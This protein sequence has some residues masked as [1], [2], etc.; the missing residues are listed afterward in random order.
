MTSSGGSVAVHRSLRRD[1]MIAV[2]APAEPVTILIVDDHAVVREGLRRLLTAHDDM[3][4]TGE[5]GG[6]AT[7][8]ALAARERPDII[9]L[10]IGIPDGDD[11]AAVRQLL[12]TSPASSVIVVSRR[13]GPELVQAALAAGARG[14]LPMNIQ[15]QELVVAIRAVLADP[16]RIVLG[17]S[18][19]SLAYTDTARRPETLSVREREILGLVGQALSNRQ[20]ASRLSLTE[21]TVKRHLRNIFVK[22]GAV[23]R[24]DA[25]NKAGHGGRQAGHGSRFPGCLEPSGRRRVTVLSRGAGNP[26][27]PRYSS[28]PA[29]FHRARSPLRYMRSPGPPNGSATKRPLVS[30]GWPR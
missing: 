12:A 4:V 17:V 20:I 6:L 2:G 24:I 25:V 11:G 22:L 8:L 28:W 23:S 7:A 14:Y 9:L 16:D 21:A 10:D 3:R 30:P 26:A 27:W 1:L 29:P 13:E 5:A 18:R 19:A 15:A